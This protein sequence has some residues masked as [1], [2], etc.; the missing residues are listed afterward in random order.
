MYENPG[1]QFTKIADGFL[2]DAERRLCVP[3]GRVR[4]VLIQ[5]GLEAIVKGHLGFE[6]FYQDLSRSFTW[7]PMRRDVK[8]YVRSCDSC[9]SPIG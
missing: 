4:M 1:E 5:D 8:E 7:P 9:Q 6:K 2:Y 3:N